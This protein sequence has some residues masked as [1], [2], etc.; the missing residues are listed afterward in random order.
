M[1]ELELPGNA[2]YSCVKHGING[3]FYSLGYELKALGILVQVLMPGFVKTEV[4]LNS[5]TASGTPHGKMDS[6]HENAMSAETFSKK[7]FPKIEAGHASIVVTGKE[8]IALPIRRL[9]PKF[10]RF[11]VNKFAK[12]F[13]KERIANL[14]A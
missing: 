7:V 11:A 12:R 1:G 13:L 8:G 9:F 4:S 3:Y 2:T 5:I 10:Y 14:P 6:T